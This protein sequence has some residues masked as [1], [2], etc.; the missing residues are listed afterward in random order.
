M[1]DHRTALRL[2]VI[3]PVLLSQNNRQLNR[4]QSLSPTDFEGSRFNRWFRQG[5]GQHPLTGSPQHQWGFLV[6]GKPGNR[7][8]AC[9]S[10]ALAV[11]FGSGQSPVVGHPYHQGRH[12]GRGLGAG[13]SW[14][15]HIW[16]I[17]PSRN[18][19]RSL[20]LARSALSWLTNSLLARASALL[21]RASLSVARAC[22]GAISAPSGTLITHWLPTFCPV[23]NPL[24]NL[25][26]T[27]F[28]ET[29]KAFAALIIESC[30]PKRVTH[31]SNP[32]P[33]FLGKPLP[34]VPMLGKGGS[35]ASVSALRLAGGAID[36]CSVFIQFER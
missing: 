23:S 6:S 10:G 16:L 12:Q 30:I 28:V 5:S 20:A 9:C 32:K 22:F 34:R 25:R 24:V 13:F 35:T 19:I 15:A 21:A 31:V 7:L 36:N 4:P 17:C 33:V 1:C 26:L 27:V 8:T 29:P 14:V 11:L 18:V 2:R 3:S